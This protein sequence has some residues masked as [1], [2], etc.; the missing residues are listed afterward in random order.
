MCHILL[1]KLIQ[2]RQHDRNGF[3][4]LWKDVD[5]NTLVNKKG[6]IIP[7]FLHGYFE[8]LNELT[9]IKALEPFI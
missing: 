3:Y 1:Q 2:G 4:E 9:T 6:T 7:I 5:L 8:A